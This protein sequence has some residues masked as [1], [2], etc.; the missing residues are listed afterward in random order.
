MHCMERNVELQYMMLFDL[1]LAFTD[2]VNFKLL[3]KDKDGNFVSDAVK[4]Y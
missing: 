4:D 3:S 1:E 2:T